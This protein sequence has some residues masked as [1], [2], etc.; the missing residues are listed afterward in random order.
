MSILLCLLSPLKTKEKSH[1]RS[2]YVLAEHPYWRGMIGEIFF[3]GSKLC[4]K[5]LLQRCLVF[6]SAWQTVTFHV[7]HIFWRKPVILLLPL[8]I[9]KTQPR[10][11]DQAEGGDSRERSLVL[12]IR[13]HERKFISAYEGQ[14]CVQLL[15]YHY[16]ICA[17]LILTSIFFCRTRLFPESTVRNIMFQILQGLAFI[18]KHGRSAE[19]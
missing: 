2:M 4:S 6:Y 17:F 18:H 19:W 13:V 10:Q 9:K 5:N 16:F 7:L 12:H 14:V 15:F 11:R 1:L 3:F 8:V